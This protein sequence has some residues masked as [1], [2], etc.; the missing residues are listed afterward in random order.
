MFLLLGKF[1]EKGNLK[2]RKIKLDNFKHEK[3]VYGIKIDT[4]GHEYQAL[5]GAKETLK[6]IF[7]GYNY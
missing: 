5:K 1:S 2:V 7:T 3:N 4:E 6:K